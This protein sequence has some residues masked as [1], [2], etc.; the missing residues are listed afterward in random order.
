MKNELIKS[1][2]N[3]FKYDIVNL[4]NNKRNHILLL[5]DYHPL[6]PTEKI[7]SLNKAGKIKLIKTRYDPHTQD[8]I[9]V[10]SKLSESYKTLLVEG[11]KK[12]VPLQKY[13]E[14]LKE[15]N[16]KFEIIKGN[17]SEDLIGKIF[18]LY[19]EVIDERGQHS[20]DSRIKEEINRLQNKR[21]DEFFIPSI[22]NSI[23]QGKVIQLIGYG[24]L[25]S[26]RKKLRKKDIPFI[27]L[28]PKSKAQCDLRYILLN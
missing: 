16:G 18:N 7:L 9:K 5:G 28:K 11:V 26:L 19:R 25:S 27:S 4:C 22:A 21:E 3:K 17:D 2:C 13:P 8:V 24:H 1:I 6:F 14:Y 12:N 15:L 23:K 20:T 10:L